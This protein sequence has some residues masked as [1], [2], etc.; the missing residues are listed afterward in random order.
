MA[1]AEAVQV[2]A[3]DVAG[4]QL[5]WMTSWRCLCLNEVICCT[6]SRVAHPHALGNLLASTPFLPCFATHLPS[7]A[8]ATSSSAARSLPGLFWQIS[9]I[10]FA[11]ARMAS[12]RVP[13]PNK[14][15]NA[16]A[17]SAA[18]RSGADLLW[19]H[20]PTPMYSARTA[21]S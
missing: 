4:V 3:E 16:E 10:S 5:E 21:L 17:N 6:G 14:V 12:D 9:P 1:E 13:L 2:D 20:M 15:M 8:K 18:S 7:L 11:L 19:P